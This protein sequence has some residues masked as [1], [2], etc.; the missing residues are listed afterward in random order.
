M[1][2]KYKKKNYKK[3]YLIYKEKFDNK[4]KAVKLAK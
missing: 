1:N 4:K 3:I 2:K